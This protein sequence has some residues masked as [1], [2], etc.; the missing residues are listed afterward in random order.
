MRQASFSHAKIAALNPLHSVLSWLSS[1]L[2][3]ALIGFSQEILKHTIFYPFQI[4]VQAYSL[5]D[6]SRNLAIAATTVFFVVAVIQS[7]WPE[8]NAQG[9]GFSPI[10]VLHRTFTQII[11]AV[12]SLPLVQGLLLF[13]NRIVAAL[14]AS[15][16][17]TFHFTSHMALLTDPIT[18]IVLTLAVVVL[19]AMLGVYYAV[20]DIEIVV[21]LSLIPWFALF[22]MAQTQR[23]E[24]L[25]RVLK[26]L[27][28]AIFIQSIQAM[29]FYLFIHMLANQGAGT[30]MGQVE[31]I[32]LLYYVVK[33]PGQLRR[34]AGTV[35]P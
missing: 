14:L 31:E 12:F 16:T 33:L 5:F 13:N 1:G 35:G 28:I 6:F 2:N 4:P 30:V 27:L 24:A 25:L 10:H 22:W 26:E 15:S 8:L 18:T 20:R 23:S 11:W 32:G 9:W 17:I 34:L 3:Q 21:L 29:A 19:V 7:Q